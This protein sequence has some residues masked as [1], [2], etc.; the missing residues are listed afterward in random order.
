MKQR[1]T[2]VRALHDLGGA[3]WFGGALMGAV[4]LNGASRAVADP[5]DR[6]PVATA[7]WARWAPVSAGAIGA[8]LIGGLGLLIANRDRVRGQ[9]GVGTNTTTKTALTVAALA[10]TAYS[11]VLGA[12]MAKAGAVPSDGG[13]TPSE[14]TPADTAATQQRLR[15]LQWAIP[16]LTGAIVILGSQQGEQQRSGEVLRG[17]AAKFAKRDRAGLL[18]G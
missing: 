9:S 11:G 3:A 10:T 13:T 4:G 18:A 12:R 14:S 17:L 15:A 2:I 1:N 16:V 6:A 5:L 8:H 7:G